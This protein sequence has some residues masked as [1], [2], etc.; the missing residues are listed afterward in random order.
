MLDRNELR[1]LLRGYDHI[2]RGRLAQ[3]LDA[4]IMALCAAQSQGPAVIEYSLDD[5]IDGVCTSGLQGIV[6]ALEDG[7]PNAEADDLRRMA[8]PGLAQA[9][10]THFGSRRHTRRRLA[11]AKRKTERTDGR[12]S[13]SQRP[14]PM[15][16]NHGKLRAHL[17]RPSESEPNAEGGASPTSLTPLSA[18]EAQSRSEA[19][20]LDRYANGGASPSDGIGSKTLEP[21]SS[22]RWRPFP[23]P[24][25][26][27]ALAAIVLCGFLLTATSYNYFFDQQ[28]RAYKTFFELGS[29]EGLET[30]EAQLKGKSHGDYEYYLKASAQYRAGNL[31]QARLMVNRIIAS[32]PNDYNSGICLYLL[33][34]IER[35][36]GVLEISLG[37]FMD[38]LRYFRDDQHTQQFLALLEIA[39]TYLGLQDIQKAS[40]YFS[41]AEV[42]R[43]KANQET[44]GQYEYFYYETLGRIRLGL[45]NP[46]GLLEALEQA[47]N[48]IENNYQRF[49]YHAWRAWALWSFGDVESA[50][51]DLDK[52]QYLI[53]N[54]RMQAHFD[55]T[56]IA[57]RHCRGVDYSVLEQN[58]Q[59]WLQ[60]NPSEW[61]ENKLEQAVQTCN[62]R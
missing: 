54:G 9:W 29:R 47:R 50:S 11:P 16:R 40:S 36:S 15:E 3:R 46:S 28:L 32:D 58:V 8:G 4:L 39:K 13:H 30:L 27:K 26:V 38:A 61:L 42:A 56:K 53:A 19:P 33:G 12:S 14:V 57:I 48:H 43:G 21:D 1:R 10:R 45:G 31:E 62:H 18:S 25:R 55:A 60:K 24:R 37:H 59:L 51:I 52:A 6:E 20:G 2:E 17:Q 23:P 49:N 34:A 5:R 35:D 7:L 41:L 22:R 44:V